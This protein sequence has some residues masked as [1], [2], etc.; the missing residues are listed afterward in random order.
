MH[1]CLVGVNIR[2]TILQIGVG[3]KYEPKLH[4]AT[5]MSDW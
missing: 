1:D 3:L 4:A 2:Q 5:N